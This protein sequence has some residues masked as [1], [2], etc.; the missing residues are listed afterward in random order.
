MNVTEG[1]I[2]GLSSLFKNKMRSMLTMLGII[3]G[4]SGVVGTVSI[5]SGAKKLVLSEFERIG[6]SN[7][8]VIWRRDW[9][10]VSGQWERIKSNEYL[11]NED[12]LAIAAD[13]G[14]DI[15]LRA[16]CDLGRFTAG[17]DRGGCVVLLHG[18]RDAVFLVIVLHFAVADGGR[19][20]VEDG[21]ARR[22]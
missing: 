6:A 17:V 4:I 2:I 20:V 12:A 13:A 18:G 21:Q 3:I 9:V 22:A 11:D 10:R 15:Q 19:A 7:T 16:G 14:Q 1:F 5:G 8:V